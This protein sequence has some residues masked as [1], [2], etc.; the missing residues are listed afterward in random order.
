M[1]TR[2]ASHELEGASSLTTTD[3]ARSV[4]DRF[5]PHVTNSATAKAIPLPRRLRH[6]LEAAIFFFGIG[7]FHLFGVKRASD[8]GGWIGRT[9]ISPTRASRR[10]RANLALA[11]PEKSEA[12]IERIVRAMWDNLGRVGA[13]Y[14]YLPLMHSLGPHPRI[15]V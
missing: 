5:A 3:S 4:F 15:T 13:E 11:Y 2:V 10:A 6:Y 7:F 12:E 8:I 1:I 9:L 14:G